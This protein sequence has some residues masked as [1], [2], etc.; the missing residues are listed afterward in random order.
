MYRPRVLVIDPSAESQ[1][2]VRKVLVKHCELIC[3]QDSMHLFEILEM[4]EPDL[5]V[6]ELDLPHLS[7]FDVIHLVQSDPILRKIPILVFS[8]RHSVE[9]QKLAYR[10]GAMHFQAKPCRPSQLFKGA[11]MFWRLACESSEAAPV[12]QFDLQEVQRRL[13]E[14]TTEERPDPLL[15][16]MVAAYQ[17][18][19]RYNGSNVGARCVMASV[20]GGKAVSSAR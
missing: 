11:A 6:L 9:N 12:K 16:Q 1:A 5:I 19:I 7:G 10:L 2:L 13:A 20:A 14:Y 8:E 18:R 4:F 3:R 17:R 15:Q